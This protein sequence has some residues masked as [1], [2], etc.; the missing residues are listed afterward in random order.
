MTADRMYVSRD[1]RR[2]MAVSRVPTR[3]RRAAREPRRPAACSKVPRCEARAEVTEAAADS[4]SSTAW[5][6]VGFF[7][8]LLVG[9]VVFGCVF[10][11]VWFRVC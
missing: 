10:V 4:T 11:V 5:L 9:V 2:R 1:L 3:G 7:I 6:F 8:L